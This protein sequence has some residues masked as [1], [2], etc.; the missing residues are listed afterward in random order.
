MKRK[1]IDAEKFFSG[2]CD[3]IA[4]ADNYEAIPKADVAEFAFAGRSNVGKSSLINALT[5]RVK[6]VRTSHTPGRTQQVNFFSLRGE[7][8]LVDL[9]GYGYAK[10][11]KTK[12]KGWNKLIKDYLR[13]RKTL[14]RVFLLIDSRRGVKSSDEEIMNLLDECA[15]NYQVVFTKIDKIKKVDLKKLLELT[16]KLMKSHS[17]LNPRILETSSHGKLGLAELRRE[18][19]SLV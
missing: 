7:F 2:E 11:S 1:E 19:V 4:G 14:K 12:I 8:N 16:D 6:L 3:F 9:P 17:A 15:V 10:V 18:I 5:F 13:G